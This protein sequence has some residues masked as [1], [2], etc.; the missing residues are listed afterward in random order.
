MGLIP[1]SP[2][3]VNGDTIPPTPGLSCLDIQ[4]SYCGDLPDFYEAGKLTLL[5]GPATHQP[6]SP[7]CGGLC[8]C[9]L[10]SPLQ[11]A[12]FLGP[13]Q[14]QTHRLVPQHGTQE[15]Q[16]GVRLR[17]HPCKLVFR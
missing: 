6:S 2:M 8:C 14:V 13:L 12:C 10:R 16:R 9:D 3:T 15:D 17:P 5:L 7:G 4:A 1:S 11:L